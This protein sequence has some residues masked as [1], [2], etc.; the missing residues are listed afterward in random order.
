MLLPEMTREQLKT[1]TPEQL[2]EYV[3]IREQS[4]Y[5]DCRQSFKRY[6]R[7]V[8]VPGTPSPGDVAVS[9]LYRLIKEERGETVEDDKP[10][11]VE[12]YPK[13]LKPA[14]HHDLIM[15]TIE[16]MVLERLRAPE[17]E[18]VD[19]CMLFLPPG[20]A[21]STYSSML[22]PA[23]FMSRF[24]NFNV[25]VASYAQ[26]VAN[27]FS[28]RARSIVG[29]DSHKLIFPNT[30]FVT[31][32][33]QNWELTNG[34]EF[35]AAGILAAVTSFRADLLITDDPVAGRE[36]AE[37]ELIP[38]KIH[39]AYTDDLVTRLKPGG[40]QCLIMTRWAENDLAGMILG[41]DW[42]GQSG[43]WKGTDGRN[44]YVVCLP[45]LAEHHDDPLGRAI[46]ELLWPEWFSMRDTRVLQ[47]AAKKGGNAARTWASLHQ[48]RPAPVEG[49]IL[50]RSYWREWKQKDKHGDP[51]PPKCDFVLLAYDT[52][53][54]EDESNDWSAMTAWGCFEHVSH[55]DYSGEEFNHPH[56]ILLGAWRE[57][58]QAADL[59]DA[60]EEQYRF[61]RMGMKNPPRLLVEKRAS[62]HQLIQELRR[63]NLPVKQ[64]LP[65][66][67]PGAKGKVP[68]AHGVAM[69][70]EQGSVWYIPG[71][72][73]QM[74]IDECAA[75][76]NGRY[77]DWVDTVTCALT[78]MR[79][80]FWFK[81]ADE[82]MEEDERR[83]Y[84]LNQRRN[85]QRR[86]NVYGTDHQQG[87]DDSPYDN[88][89]DNTKRQ[90]YGNFD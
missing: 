48:Q 20:A 53:I 26:A 8:E 9:D 77:D 89:T 2:R 68:R 74:V 15:D 62:G 43:H 63:R 7:Y 27:R 40:K 66:G 42:D 46:G 56:V 54:E 39:E 45:R 12:L 47:E 83:E 36:E 22:A 71:R 11:D 21:K 52:A 1:L 72:W 38:E 14:T 73:T 10:D 35:R 70:L 79:D 4:H 90:L 6:A 81:T 51:L 87:I 84:I 86:R 67:R 65:K 60:V 23:Y 25:I 32:D 24:S 57:R 19:G 50:M 33:V 85:R 55:R 37:S 61:F 3:A 82:E 30:G 16:G 69:M 18:P 44:W 28:R 29:S 59:A 49:S 41:E 88:M 31:E 5:K 17:G 75:F 76:P 80:H 58:L 34:S 64:W 78:Y 13:R